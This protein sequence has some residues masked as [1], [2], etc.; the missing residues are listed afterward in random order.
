MVLNVRA[1]FGA[2]V[3]VLLSATLAAC[4]GSSQNSGSATPVISGTPA[5]TVVAGTAYEFKPTVNAAGA[6]VELTV[7]NLP[8]WAVFDAATGKLSGTPKATH[9]GVYANIS[10]M[11][12]NGTKT[13]V[14]GPFSIKVEAVAVQLAISGV[15]AKTAAVGMSYSFRPTT[16]SAGG[17]TLSFAAVHLPGWAKFDPATGSLSGTPTTADVGPYAQI[18]ISVS[19]GAAT[20][21]LAPFSIDVTSGSSVVATITWPTPA[22]DPSGTALAGY[23]V[24]YGTSIAGMTRVADVKD[25]TAT[26]YVIDNLNPG[27]WYFAIAS[28]DANKTQSALSP[29]VAVNL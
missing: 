22:A 10:I 14:L 9:V 5:S 20:A 12:R 27:T 16:T 4:N 19:D 17:A 26:S 3:F 13:A 23:R 29:T 18:T 15:P 1:R 2:L 24:Y 6:H 21:S 7:A 25:P 11:A 28:Y 8:A